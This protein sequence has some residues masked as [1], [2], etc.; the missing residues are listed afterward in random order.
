MLILRVFHDV[1]EPRVGKQGMMKAANL[2]QVAVT[3]YHSYLKSLSVMRKYKDRGIDK[4]P[5]IASKY[6]K[7]ISHNQPFEAVEYMEKKV[8][9]MEV[10]LNDHVTKTMSGLK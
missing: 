5:S 8:K 9:D 7:Y 10:K 2:A 1:F 3:V 6:I 4:H